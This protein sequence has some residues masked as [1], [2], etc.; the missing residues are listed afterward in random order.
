[1]RILLQLE[2]LNDQKVWDA[3]EYHKVQGFVYDKLIANT[4]YRGIHDSNAYKFFCF[5]NIFPPTIVK[6]GQTRSLLFSSPNLDLIN[7]VFTHAK[8][9]L[10]G[11]Q[12]INIGE[13][14]YRLKS[15]ALLEARVVENSCIIRTSTPVTIRIPEKAYH[16]YNIEEQ[17]RKKKF[18]YW[19]SNLSHD[20]FIR[21]IFNNLKSKFKRYYN[22]DPVNIES[23]LQTFVLLKEVII[24][25]PI[26][27]YTAKIPASFWRFQFNDLKNEH[28]DFLNF[29]LDIG[30]GERNSAGLGFLNAE[31]GTKTALLQRV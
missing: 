28:K 26:H 18:L 27:E 24:H 16:N 31:E 7:S 8:E 29:A 19:R 23:T 17:Y 13:Q 21:M 2:A 25:I 6:V 15:S 22:A 14:Q 3:S 9:I 20:I 1:M 10:T 5:S 11:S 12:L 30:I 4:K